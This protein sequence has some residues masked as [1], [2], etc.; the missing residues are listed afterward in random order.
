MLFGP[1]VS[2]GVRFESVVAVS[3]PDLLCA[4]VP[5]VETTKSDAASRIEREILVM[6]ECPRER[7]ISAVMVAWLAFPKLGLCRLLGSLDA[8]IAS[9]PIWAQTI[10][11]ARGALPVVVKFCANAFACPRRHGPQQPQPTIAVDR[12][13]SPL[14]SRI[15]GYS[16]AQALQAHCVTRRDGRP[17]LCAIPAFAC[18]RGSHNYHLPVIWCKRH[19]GYGAA[20]PPA[21]CNVESPFMA[22]RFPYKA[23]FPRVGCPMAQAAGATT[24]SGRTES[25][26]QH[27]Y[28]LAANVIANALSIQN[29]IIS[30]MSRPRERQVAPFG[31]LG[32]REVSP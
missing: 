27:D 19:F 28:G 15:G 24:G 4:N 12:L 29:L 13:A 1:A 21:G 8:M 26:A 2:A 31:P 17:K 16:Q 22:A 23:W 9:Q 10:W 7:V 25:P 32:R 30:D 18:S 14:R 6:V 20:P 3:P 11:R 5:A